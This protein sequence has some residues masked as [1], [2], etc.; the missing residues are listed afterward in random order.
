MKNLIL[1]TVAALALMST[2]VQADD[3]QVNLEAGNFAV[4]TGT[5]LVPGV[6]GN[7]FVGKAS[8]SVE[9]VGA[10]SSTTQK[11]VDGD[12]NQANLGGLNGSYNEALIVA[13]GVQG[14]LLVNKATQSVLAVGAQT[15]MSQTN[16]DAGED[17]LNVT[18]LNGALNTGTIVAVG[19]QVNLLTNK[20]TQ[21]VAAVG[22]GSFVSQKNVGGDNQTN[23]SLGNFAV[24]T[25]T[26]VA[27]GVQLN[28]GVSKASQSVSGVG[29]S[30]STSQVNRSN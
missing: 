20:A 21:S 13:A 12:D 24:N 30:A 29:A 2:A 16:R 15:S 23:L 17:Q 1:S 5:I 7:L 26:V 18:A 9:A 27:G 8:Q 3:N 14:N 6:Q 10:V 22:A 28:G 19:G 25:A 11:N 4:N